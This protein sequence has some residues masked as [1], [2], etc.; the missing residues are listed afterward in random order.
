MKFAVL[1]SVIVLTAAC[2]ARP[3]QQPELPP[4]PPLPDSVV[5]N[6]DPEIAPL[7][8]RSA[9]GVAEL[10]AAERVDA[11]LGPIEFDRRLAAVAEDTSA[12]AVVRINALQLLAHRT[13][14]NHL[15]AFSS[16]LDAPEERVRMAAVSGMRD[17]LPAAPNTAIG[18][19]EKALR[20]P[21]PRIQ[22]RAL[23]LLSDRDERV[24]REYHARATNAELRDVARDLIRVAE[25][26]GAPLVARD[27]TGTLERVT[28]AGVIITFQPAQR[29][30]QWDAALGTLLVTPPKGKPV[31]V[32]SSVE[33]VG[34]VV[35]A[36]MAG[37]SLLVYEVNREIHVR[38]LRDN[39]DRKLTNGIAPRM[40]PFTNDVVFYREIAER[41]MSTPTDVPYRYQVIRIPMAGGAEAVL[42]EV[43]VS[44]KNNV[45]GNYSPV[46][47]SRVRELNGR[48]YLVGENMGEFQLP[49]PFGS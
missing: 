37:D 34:N 49:S 28:D 10:N 42:G 1:L 22:T 21:N 48:F 31:Q 29:W 12:P 40:L 17:F 24:L 46:R 33:V 39:S 47:W 8:R 18:I 4:P 19:L 13:A 38:S 45:K 30:P 20:D 35:P 16:A 27:S 25:G 2:G 3:Q 11:Y 44:V 7:L 15:I 41:R 32:A 23:E 26:R 43:K 36:F 5:W 14:V 6:G 9:F